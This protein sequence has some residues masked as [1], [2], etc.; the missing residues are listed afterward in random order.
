MEH[1]FKI[2]LLYKNQRRMAS[3]IDAAYRPDDS[4][5]DR[6]VAEWEDLLSV[7]I[8]DLGG[9]RH[10]IMTTAFTRKLT[11][12][13]MRNIVERSMWKYD[14]NNPDVHCYQLMMDTV[15]YPVNTLSQ[16]LK[17]LHGRIGDESLLPKEDFDCIVIA[18][19]HLLARIKKILAEEAEKMEKNN[20]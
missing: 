5:F 7:G 9:T 16:C 2:V 10:T 14:I 19:P 8:E 11:L 20:G 3:Y 18:R 1:S 15:E 4:M 13:S 17:I 6:V 12:A